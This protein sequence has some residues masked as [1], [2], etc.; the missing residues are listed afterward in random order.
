MKNNTPK[1]TEMQIIIEYD[2]IIKRTVIGHIKK[3]PNIKTLAAGNENA[4]KIISLAE[5]YL[6]GRII[7]CKKIADAFYVAYFTVFE[8]DI[9]LS[10]NFK[11]LAKCEGRTENI[12]SK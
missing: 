2:R 7:L 11:H 6:N 9:L 1:D 4:K 3:Y 8:I 12:N 10:W 5:A